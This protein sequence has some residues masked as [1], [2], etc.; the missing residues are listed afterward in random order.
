MRAA[1]RDYG[2]RLLH[3]LHGHT[4]QSWNADLFWR[5]ILSALARLIWKPRYQGFEHIPEHGPCL[6]IANH[7]SYLDG[8]LIAAGS[9]RPIRFVIDGTIYHLPVVHY[10]MKHNRAIPILPTRESV[11]AAL[12]AIAEGLQQ[13]DA[14]CIFPEGKL[15]FTG[16]LSRFKPG[17]EW[18]IKR[19]QVMVYPIGIVGLWGSVFS[20][21]Y[22]QKR[23][24]WWP[25]HW[26]LP[27]ALACGEG[28]APEHIS[29]NYLQRRIIQLKHEAAEL[30]TP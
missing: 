9:K 18:I 24:R 27:I 11:S 10:F 1:L 19:N 23:L 6:L 3:R 13:G 22:L 16:S 2:Q 20:R 5:P 12:D 28:I 30:H 4:I 29:I 21:K 26:H 8:L 15:T 25:R 7:V 14:I 17:V